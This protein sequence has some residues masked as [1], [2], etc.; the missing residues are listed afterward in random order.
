MRYRLPAL[1]LLI[2]P[3]LAAAADKPAVVELF[4]DDADTLI[5]QLTMFASANKSV[6]GY[7]S[8]TNLRSR[9]RKR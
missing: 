2:V 8:S 3:A 1:L 4:E 5:P 7:F 6:P 9:F